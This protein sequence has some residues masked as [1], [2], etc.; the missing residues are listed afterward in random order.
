[1][2][3]SGTGHEGNLLKDKEQGPTDPVFHDEC[4]LEKRLYEE[5]QQE[6]KRTREREIEK[7][8]IEKKEERGTGG[9][10]EEINTY[11]RPDYTYT[12]DM[13]IAMSKVK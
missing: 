2:G 10:R 11:I 8:G 7:R 13:S 12:Y 9:T 4:V 5:V 6:N 3:W 1:M